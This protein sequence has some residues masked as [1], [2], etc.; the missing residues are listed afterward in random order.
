MIGVNYFW[1]LLD[2]TVAIPNSLGDNGLTLTTR[3]IGIIVARDNKLYASNANG[4]TQTTE[5]ITGITFTDENNYKIVFDSG[6]NIKFYVNDV[7]KSTSTTNLPSGSTN[8]PDVRFGARFGQNTSDIGNFL[9]YNNYK[10]I[11]T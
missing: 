4:T 10:L 7:L 1:G 5:E 2:N 6:T 8:P 3:H 11:K 9:L